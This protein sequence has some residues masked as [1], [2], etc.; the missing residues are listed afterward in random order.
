MVGRRT[1]TTFSSDSAAALEVTL[2]PALSVAVHVRVQY[3]VIGLP[4]RDEG[5]GLVS[6]GGVLAAVA[7]HVGEVEVV[8]PNARDRRRDA[9]D[10]GLA[11]FLTSSTAGKMCVWAKST[12]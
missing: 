6:M 8:A 3:D 9:E 4:V 1:N 12:R 5:L 10:A 11:A 2:A 7:Q